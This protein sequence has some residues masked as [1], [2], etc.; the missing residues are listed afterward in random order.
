LN[1]Q[2]TTQTST[3][4]DLLWSSLFKPK[5]LKQ[6]IGLECGAQPRYLISH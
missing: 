1:A 2:E 3:W 4:G 5:S 6:A